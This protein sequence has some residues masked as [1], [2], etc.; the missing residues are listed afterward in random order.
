MS[1]AM[2]VDVRSTPVTRANPVAKLGACLIVTLTLLL[3]VDWVSA[4]VALVLQTAVL[5][6]CGLA[7]RVLLRR[8]APV[9]VAA[10]PAGVV[11][12][13]IGV[14]GGRM[15]A[16]LG[17]LDVTE[18]SLASGVAIT[19]RVLA[20]GVPGVVLLASTDPTDLA[21]ALAQRLHL[22]ARFVLGG[23]AGLRL[24]GL[25]VADWRT[26][27]LARRARGVGDGSGPLGSA[28]VLGGQ[29]FALL[30]LA[31]RRGTRLAT[32]MEARGFGAPVPRSW[33]RSSTFAARDVGVALGGVVI[34]ASSA[35][36]ALLAGSWTFILG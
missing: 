7:P 1:F 21:D 6:L 14:D 12:C 2:C 31:V 19:L 11:T 15:L 9:L 20:V 23:L 30:V 17:W 28:R 4:A 5:P 16:D 34:A 26:L 24:V 3:S 18:G 29:A 32:A 8:L 33:A 10:G 13:F 25:M 22:P 27:A 35:A 36:T